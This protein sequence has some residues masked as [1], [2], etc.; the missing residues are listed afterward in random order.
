MGIGIGIPEPQHPRVQPCLVVHQAKPGLLAVGELVVLA[1]HLQNHHLSAPRHMLV[2]PPQHEVRHARPRQVRDERAEDQAQALWADVRGNLGQVHGAARS[3]I[4]AGIEARAAIG[5]ACCPGPPVHADGGHATMA[6]PR[7]QNLVRDGPALLFARPRL[8]RAAHILGLDLAETLVQLAPPR[9]REGIRLVVQRSALERRLE[10]EGNL[11]VEDDIP[12][13]QR[14][15]LGPHDRL[16]V[17]P[18]P[19]LPRVVLQH[20]ALHV[21]HLVVVADEADSSAHRRDILGRSVSCSTRALQRTR[22]EDDRLPRSVCRHLIVQQHHVLLRE[23]SV[24]LKSALLYGDPPSALQLGIGEGLGEGVVRVL[25]PPDVHEVQREAVPP[26]PPQAGAQVRSGEQILQK[27]YH[28][29][30]TF[31]VSERPELLH[32]PDRSPHC[33]CQDPRG[34]EL[35]IHHRQVLPASALLSVLSVLSVLSAGPGAVFLQGVLQMP[36][37]LLSQYHRHLFQQSP[38][39]VSLVSEVACPI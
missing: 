4:G 9:G 30:P 12:K 8:Q 37:D 28:H 1:L 38:R 6:R 2:L 18:Q 10:H 31:V 34:C 24:Y 17:L 14:E 7:I 29:A 33:V 16:R 26:L 36:G 15:Q 3:G 11:V 23:L 22:F 5:A 27:R 39:H 35:A 32:Q 19:A 13:Q 20:E 25:E 21:H